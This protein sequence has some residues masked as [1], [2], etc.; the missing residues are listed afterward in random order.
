MGPHTCD[1]LDLFD[2][3]KLLFAEERPCENANHSADPNHGG[4]G[5]WFLTA[6]TCQTCSINRGVRLVCD[7]F[8]QYILSGGPIACGKC[9]VF[10]GNG[11][12]AYK[13]ITP[14]SC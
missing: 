2:D 4:P 1:S 6:K 13:S 11:M 10:L 9:K 14:K 8:A 7:S 3:L 5:E 12:E